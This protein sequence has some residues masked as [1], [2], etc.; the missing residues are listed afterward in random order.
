[1]GD[2]VRHMLLSTKKKLIQNIKK[3]KTKVIYPEQC[4]ENERQEVRIIDN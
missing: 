3:I 1:M 2:I 4:I